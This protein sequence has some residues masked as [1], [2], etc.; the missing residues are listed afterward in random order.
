MRFLKPV[1]PGDRMEIDVQV[2]KFSGDFAIVEAVV[3][4]NGVEVAGGKLGFARR[5]LQA[6]TA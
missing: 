2:L 5:S 6:G 4:V 3:T 1:I